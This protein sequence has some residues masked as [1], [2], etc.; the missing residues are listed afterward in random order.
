M[1]I[2]TSTESFHSSQLSL[3]DDDNNPNETGGE[4]ISSYTSTAYTSTANN[5]TYKVADT[6][7]NRALYTNPRHTSS[8][9]SGFLRGIRKFCCCMSISITEDALENPA[10]EEAKAD[11]LEAPMQMCQTSENSAVVFQ[12]SLSAGK[13][14]TISRK[15]VMLSYCGSQSNRGIPR[16]VEHSATNEGPKALTGGFASENKNVGS[17]YYSTDSNFSKGKSY[18]DLVSYKCYCSLGKGGQGS[19]VKVFHEQKEYAMKKTK[20]RE[21]EIEIHAEL[22]HENIIPLLAVI[23]GE[24]EEREKVFELKSYHLMPSLAYDL[25]MLECS[26]RED[27]S[28]DDFKQMLKSS[29][30]LSKHR[31]LKFVLGKILDALS[32][33]HSEGFVH[34]DVKPSNVMLTMCSKNHYLLHCTCGENA[35]EVKLGDFGCACKKTNWDRPDSESNASG[36]T[37]SYRYVGT[38]GYR[39]PE[40]AMSFAYKGPHQKFYT[41][42]VDIWSFASLVFHFGSGTKLATQ[43]YHA[44]LLLAQTNKNYQDPL[45]N[46]IAKLKDTSIFNNVPELISLIEECLS[47]DFEK[48]PTADQAKKKLFSNS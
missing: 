22:K 6:R 24:H 44:R 3:L 31:N 28:S 16:Q 26:Y 14:S 47:F 39:A 42:A 2:S 33:M 9:G 10:L 46:K 25:S 20:F 13:G 27:Y 36:S 30:E 12:G 48:R 32:Y 37:F 4:Q 40:V 38:L 34:R 17:V 43:L 8:L 1:T 35:F 19:V 23:Y 5:K 29:P 11:V 41:T 15:L 21:L 45:I 7:S 18:Q